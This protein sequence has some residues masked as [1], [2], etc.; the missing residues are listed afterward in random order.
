MDS[1]T[2][3]IPSLLNAS[4]PLSLFMSHLIFQGF[5]MLQGDFRIITLTG[6]IQEAGYGSPGPV[7][8]HT[9]ADAASL[10]CV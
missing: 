1:L 4:L 3:K 7:K 8:K 6:G 10:C 9:K 5:S 2:S